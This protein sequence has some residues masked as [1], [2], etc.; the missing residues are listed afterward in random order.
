[1]ELLS[2]LYLCA[3]VSVNVISISWCEEVWGRP[4]D[5]EFDFDGIPG[6]RHEFK[7]EVGAGKEECFHQSVKPGSVMY[8]TYEVGIL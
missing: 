1:M 4:D 8:V 6:A 3:I 7:I 2:R 5:D